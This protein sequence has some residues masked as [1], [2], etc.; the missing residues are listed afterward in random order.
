MFVLQYFGG[1]AVVRTQDVRR[2]YFVLSAVV[3][4][5]PLKAVEVSMGIVCVELLLS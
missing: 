2:L 4:N 3:T 5:S 1:E